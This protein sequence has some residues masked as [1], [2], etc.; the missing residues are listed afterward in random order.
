MKIDTTKLKNNN[1]SK[2]DK[3]KYILLSLLLAIVLIV[4]DQLS[5]DL[6][7]K[8]YEVSEGKPVIKGI[9]EI[10]HIKNKGSAWGMFHNKPV[11][12]IIIA[13][14]LI[15]LIMYVYKNLLGYKHYR[16]LRICI[17]FLL[18][19]ALSNIIDRIRI[20]SVTDF[21][22]FKFVD[23]PVFNVADIYVTFSIAIML[24]LLIFR[25]KGADIDVMLGS[26]YIDEDGKY[27]DK[28]S[29]KKTDDK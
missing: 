9:I 17:V 14:I 12:P 18:S 20:G 19:G 24:I 21:I 4:L 5:K 7:I 15:L 25:Y 2:K 6:I 26:S 13:C 28:D 10:L 22:Y 27:V 16:G 8:D 3:R 11:I 29:K 23:F 1:I